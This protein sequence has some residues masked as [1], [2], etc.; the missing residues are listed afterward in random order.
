M[1]GDKSRSAAALW[2]AWELSINQWSPEVS[3]SHPLSTGHAMSFALLLP[4]SF[5]F[6]FVLVSYKQEQ[7]QPWV[8]FTC[9]RG[10]QLFL[11]VSWP[12]SR[13]PCGLKYLDTL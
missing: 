13:G 5:Y 12:S 9:V 6:S 10:Q 1:A 11:D 4:L 3:S 8:S 2:F 7:L